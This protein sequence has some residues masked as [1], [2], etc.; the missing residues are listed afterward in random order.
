MIN[1]VVQENALS[2]ASMCF[3]KSSF[4]IYLYS[5]TENYQLQT[6]IKKIKIC[7]VQ[8]STDL[9]ERTAEVQRRKWAL[10]T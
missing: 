5:N 6:F 1:L 2:L 10:V 7:S 4:V 9:H 3:V 8:K